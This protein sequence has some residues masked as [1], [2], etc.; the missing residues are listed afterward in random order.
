VHHRWRVSGTARIV[1]SA[2]EMG[3][4]FHAKGV[5]RAVRDASCATN[6]ATQLAGTFLRRPEGAL[7]QEGRELRIGLND[8]LAPLIGA[9]GVNFVE[10]GRGSPMW[11][12]TGELE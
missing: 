5:E 7:R 2:R 6:A 9:R 12:R 8:F 3:R 10:L 11:F 4:T 1:Q